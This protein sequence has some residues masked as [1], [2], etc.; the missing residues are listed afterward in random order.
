MK[1]LALILFALLIAISVVDPL[2]PAAQ[3]AVVSGT[4]SIPDSDM[5]Y[6]PDIYGM[7]VRVLGT[8]IAANVTAAGNKYNGAFALDDVPN[9]TV[10]LLLRED[11]QDVFTQTSKRVQVNVTGDSVTGV[12]FDLAYHWKELAGYPSPWGQTGYGEWTPHF[13]SDQVGFILFRVRGTGIDPERVELYRTLDGAQTWAEI[14]DDWLS[15]NGVYPDRVKRTYYF[16]D[17]THGVIQALV[18]TNADPDVVWYNPRGLLWT[19]NGGE[20]WQY[21]ALPT[22]PDT[23]DI[24]IHRFAQISPSHLIAAGTADWEGVNADVIWESTN[25][26]ATWQIK[27]F[28]QPADGCSGLGANSD[29]KAIAFFTPY[30]WGGLKKV[31]LRDSTGNWTTI[32]DNALI[33]NSGYGPADIPMVGDNA[34]LRNTNNSTQPAGLYQT[35]NAGLNWEMVSELELP[36]MDFATENKGFGLAGGPAYVTY[37]G[38]LTWLYQSG[39]GGVCCHG[40]NIWTFDTTHAIWHETGVGDPNG[41]AQL[42]TYVEPWEPNFEV[43]PGVQIKNGYVESGDTNVPVASYKLFNHGPVPI[44]LESLAVRTSSACTYAN[45]IS[46][47]KLW[48]DQNANGYVD[49]EDALLS[50]GVYSADNEALPLIFSDELILA[51]F[52]PVHLLLTY[53]LAGD[54]YPLRTFAGS[55]MAKDVAARRTDTDVI[56]QASAPADYPIPGR[57]IT[58]AQMIFSDDFENGLVNWNVSSDTEPLDPGYGWQIADT[59]SVSPPHSAFVRE[60]RSHQNWMTNHYLTLAQSLDL[61]LEG[62]YFLTFLHRYQLD[63]G[64]KLWVEASADDGITWDPIGKYGSHE[65]SA[66][67]STGDFIYEILN[68]SDYAGVDHLLI[69]FRFDSLAGSGSYGDWFLDDVKVFHRLVPKEVALLSPAGG[70]VIPSA[71]T[72]VVEWEAP[73]KAETFK[74]LYSFDQ[75]TTW[76][77]IEA[78]VR[79]NSYCWQVPRT[80]ANKKG[81][82]VKVIGYDGSGKKVGS[83]ISNSPFTIEV[84][85]ILYP[86][87]GD[88]LHAGESKTIDWRASPEADH[89]DL[90]YSLDNGATWGAVQKGVIGAS[91]T[92][93]VPTPTTGNKAKCLIKIVA[94]NAS[95]AKVGSDLSDATFSIEVVKL[96]SPNGGQPALK[97]GDTV[98][99]T[100][101][102]YNT[103]KPIETVQLSYTKDGGT[104]WTPIKPSPA[105]P[106]SPGD[107]SHPWIPTVGAEKTK[108]KVKV[109]LKDIDGVV[110]G[111]DA[112]DSYFTI[113]P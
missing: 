41:E 50:Q 43:L 107:Y 82:L 91:L 10:T 96:T 25:A 16:S 90:T 110:R 71:W 85:K 58:T 24:N 75:G 66:V 12:S 42:F 105:G 45:D 80:G 23:Y 74:L 15:G 65:T 89:F 22:P 93:E 48:L 57:T 28:W 36:Y 104:T 100:W 67:Y 6:R 54:L 95:G 111:S 33:T 40:N 72:Y 106:F 14:G 34:W 9:G 81:C 17:Q 38:G 44:R 52:I 73:P 70:E 87:G 3:S 77:P 13:V 59:A 30:A 79:G 46:Q 7:K 60:D 102:I 20:T 1:K 97:S 4:V 92:F 53:D 8:E 5:G 112:S 99:I 94:F 35:R 84:V 98:P 69:R 26:G 64:F 86:N 103:A 62:N 2:P 21:T 83:D 101:T 32:D 11:N 31:A 109:V 55:L 68:L 27:A 61:S 108:C 37:D 88:V 113:T 18:D 51:Q 63:R 56:V 39:G 78:G 19:S 49:E 76:K 47:V 29:G